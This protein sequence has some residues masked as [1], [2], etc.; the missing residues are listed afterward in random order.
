M[1]ELKWG[2]A[3]NDGTDIVLQ[4]SQKFFLFKVKFASTSLQDFLSVYLESI[5]LFIIAKC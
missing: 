5:F 3:L 2:N 1:I 4:L